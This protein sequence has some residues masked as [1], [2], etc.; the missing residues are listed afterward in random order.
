MNS[1]HEDDLL[2]AK[3]GE[4]FRCWTLA[5][6]GQYNWLVRNCVEKNRWCKDHAPPSLNREGAGCFGVSSRSSTISISF[7]GA[8]LNC[9]PKVDACASS[10]VRTL[11]ARSPPVRSSPPVGL[12][13]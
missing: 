5:S 7:L 13:G 9:S 10:P 11:L 6:V 4:P 1:L 8:F 2:T 3:C 12:T